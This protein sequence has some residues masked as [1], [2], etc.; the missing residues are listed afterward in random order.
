MSSALLCQ[1]ILG[2][3]TLSDYKSV[4]Q[5]ILESNSIDQKLKV[6]TLIPDQEFKKVNF[7][8]Y[9]QVINDEDIHSIIL[10]FIIQHVILDEKQIEHNWGLID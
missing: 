10:K 4:L 5:F 7:T 1:N 9:Y 6:K 8:N 3:N 2:K